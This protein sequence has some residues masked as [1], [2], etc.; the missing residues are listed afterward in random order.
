MWFLT[1]SKW[2][3][4]VLQV[5]IEQ[6]CFAH[7]LKISMLYRIHSQVLQNW[8]F[9]NI[10]LLGIS[11]LWKQTLIDAIPFVFIKCYFTIGNLVF[12]LEIGIPMD[13]NPAPYWVSL[14]LHFFEC[15]YVQEWI[16]KDSLHASKF[17]GTS[18]KIV[19]FKQFTPSN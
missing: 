9:K 18:M 19:Y 6:N 5:S 1:F 4:T 14:V 12:K 10:S 7:S 15:I 11:I 13:M 16:S 2:F 17:H 3:L 8:L